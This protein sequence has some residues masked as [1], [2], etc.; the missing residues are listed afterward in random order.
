MSKKDLWGSRQ[1]LE[2]WEQ[3]GLTFLPEPEALTQDVQ[4][5]AVMQQPGPGR[6]KRKRSCPKCG[7]P[8]PLIQSLYIISSNGERRR[9]EE[10]AELIVLEQRCI[11]G[12]VG[13]SD[14]KSRHST[15]YT[16]EEY[17][18]TQLTPVVRSMMEDRKAALRSVSVKVK[19]WDERSEASQR[20]I[21]TAL[22]AFQSWRRDRGDLLPS[23]PWAA[24]PPTQ[25]RV[26]EYLQS[27]TG[28]SKEWRSLS[29]QALR[30]YLL[31]VNR[32]QLADLVWVPKQ[33]QS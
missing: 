31:H 26:G 25:D 11:M 7:R 15:E 16:A 10:F 6:P 12:T 21:V 23:D 1:M 30:L 19:P 2:R 22:K 14:G 32:P 4:H 9:K 8:A 33:K 27:L 3:P 20:K 18:M 29:A 28:R 24:L 5:V 17:A 13:G